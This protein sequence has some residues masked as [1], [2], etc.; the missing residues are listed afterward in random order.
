[1]SIMITCPLCGF[2]ALFESE[3]EDHFKQYHPELL[4]PCG[5][6]QPTYRNLIQKVWDLDS[7]VEHKAIKI[8][9]YKRVLDIKEKTI[10]ALKE[11]NAA[12]HRCIAG[13]MKA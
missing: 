2:K 1:M 10:L 4:G 7:Q 13:V 9:K 11:D 8:L 12:M 5:M 3:M 6:V